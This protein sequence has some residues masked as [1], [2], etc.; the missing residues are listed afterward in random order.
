MFL[1][2]L[3]NLSI[4]SL[5]LGGKC[6]ELLAAGVI[7][8][9]RSY[10]KIKCFFPKNLKMYLFT[11]SCS[12]I[13]LLLMMVCW[14]WWMVLDDKFVFFPD[15]RS[16]VEST[17]ISSR[18]SLTC[19]GDCNRPSSWSRNASTTVKWNNRY[20]SVLVKSI[21]HQVNCKPSGNMNLIVS[22]LSDQF[23][24]HSATLKL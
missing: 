18:Q 24:L 2:L 22:A 19:N 17:K 12:C 21:L 16:F 9:R 20:V 7:I 10:D 6:S 15:N 3:K 14:W 11:F 5:W 4:G 23:F 8:N 1:R 13:G